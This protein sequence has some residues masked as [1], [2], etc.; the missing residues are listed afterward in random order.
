MEPTETA[1]ELSEKLQT[2]AA[3]LDETLARV[4]GERIGFTLIVYV[5]DEANNETVTQHV[6]NVPHE[7]AIDAMRTLVEYYSSGMPSIPF[8]ERH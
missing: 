8:H 7:D 3:E 4:A 2:I 5:P 1:R 6:S